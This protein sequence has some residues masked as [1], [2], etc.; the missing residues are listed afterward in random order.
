MEITTL[1][2]YLEDPRTEVSWL[3]S[4]PPIYKQFSRCEAAILV[5]R[6]PQPDPNRRLA[7]IQ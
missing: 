7:T 6:V 1:V 2:L 5:Q 3:G 4:P